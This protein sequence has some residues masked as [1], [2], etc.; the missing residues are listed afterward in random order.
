MK[1]IGYILLFFVSM[2]FMSCE[3]EYMPPP[4]TEP[5]YKGKAANITIKQ[6]KDRFSKISDPVLIEEELIFKGIVTGNDE[7][8]NIYK[9]IYI[10]DETA[11]INIGVEQNAVYGTY[12]VGQEVF[13]NLKD[14]Y[15]LRYGGELQIGL[16]TTNANRISWEIFKKKVQVNSWPNPKNA[17][18]QVVDLSKLTDDMA[19]Q[20]V[21]LKDVRFAN[22]GKKNYASK[23]ATSN[24]D[25]SDK[26]GKRIIVRTSQYASFSQ[27]L[28][29][30]GKGGLVGILGRFNGTWQLIL[31]TKND[32]KTFDGQEPEK[33][34]P[35]AGSFFKETF[36]KGVYQSG[37]RPKINDFKDFDMKA[38]IKY[39][40]ENG[41]A[42]IRSVRGANGAHI[43]LP[44]N[45][46]ANVKITGIN[47]IDKGEVTLNYQ[48]TANLFDSNA[49][50]NLNQI[51]VKVNGKSM[52]VASK[53]ISNAA[54]DNN[55]WYTISIPNIE[56]SNNVT[57]EFISTAESNKIGFRLDNIEL[58]GSAAGKDVIVLKGESK[59]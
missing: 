18:P 5:Q 12:Q 49:K 28:L 23:D 8:G 36:G 22:G 19:H 10:Q 58:V 17:V 52:P 7:S 43:W 6:L 11:A 26:D 9:Q 4:L 13:V 31:R 53:E 42:D 37:N 39:S 35:V 29:P 38:P 54:G 21:E 16:S 51:Q 20:L 57:V 32:V 27:D 47:T 55:K 24:E 50:A 48:L 30:V 45:R 46:E 1:N 33:V 40:E 34:K 59:K 56:Q 15:I 44:A 2:C 14:L 3:R 25:I 41:V